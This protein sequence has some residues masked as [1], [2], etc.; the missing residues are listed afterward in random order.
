[1]P[2][3]IATSTDVLA[4]QAALN[5]GLGVNIPGKFMVIETDLAA[6]PGT[7]AAGD[8]VEIRLGAGATANGGQ[9]ISS[10]NISPTGAFGAGSLNA[11]L[12]GMTILPGVNSV[13]TGT[14]DLYR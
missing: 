7:L 13:I 1:M 8:L 12:G 5:R 3:Y 9:A 2:G 4:L 11:P 6:G 14:T 10:V